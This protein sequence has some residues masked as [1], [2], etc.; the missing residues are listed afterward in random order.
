MST[1]AE[2]RRSA[3]AGGGRWPTRGDAAIF[4]SGKGCASE[5]EKDLNAT[6]YLIGVTLQ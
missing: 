6:P 2:G 1:A 4:Q 3:A 5:G